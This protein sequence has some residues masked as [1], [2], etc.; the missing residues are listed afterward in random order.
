MN[1]LDYWYNTNAD[2]KEFINNY[3]SSNIDRLNFDYDLKKDCM[4]LF[5]EGSNLEKNQV[6]TLLA[7]LKIYFNKENEQ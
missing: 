4:F 2:L 1:P 6:L 7:V 3:Y 5:S